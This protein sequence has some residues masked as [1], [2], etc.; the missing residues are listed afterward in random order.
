MEPYMRKCTQYSSE[1]KEQLLAKVFTPN[2]SST[3]ELA[4]QSGVAYATL[5][6]WIKMSKKQNVSAQQTIPLRPESQ[7][8]EA[9]VR[10]VLDTLDKTES[11]RSA[12]CREHGIYM[13]H[14]E[15]WKEQIVNGLGAVQTKK[16]KIEQQQLTKEIKKLKSELNR[17]DKALAEVSALLILK[18]K[19]DL[20]WGGE[21][22]N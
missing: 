9:K 5:Y 18:K 15:A 1:F 4:K 6:T 17:K 14:L 12:Y 2:G 21:E 20:L 8:A 7:S 22:D 19:A 3:V 11:E 13:H 10:A 16:D